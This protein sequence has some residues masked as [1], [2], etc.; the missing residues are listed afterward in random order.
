MG[1]DE[2]AIRDVHTTWIDAGHR[3]SIYRK[4]PE[5]AG[6]WPVTPTRCPRWQ[7]EVVRIVLP[8]DRFGSGM[9]D[10]WTSTLWKN[11]RLSRQVALLSA[12]VSAAPCGSR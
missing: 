5:A 1:S 6:F 10:A 7:T 3:I 8:N 2:R 9:L 12:V 11:K 4:Q